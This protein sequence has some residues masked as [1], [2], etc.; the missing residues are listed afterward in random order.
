MQVQFCN[1]HNLPFLAQSGGNGW[2]AFP[3]TKDLVIINLSN[4]NSVTVAADKK[5]A[6]IGGGAQVHETIAA[7]DAAGVVV[8]TGNCNGAGTLGVLLG[9]GYGNMMGRVG[10]GVDSILSLRLVTATGEIRTLSASQDAALFWAVKGAGPNFG[11]VTCATVR[12][13]AMT[14]DERTAWCGALIYSEDKLEQVVNAIQDLQLSAE[15]V[16]FMYFGSSGPPTHDPV[17]II[18][19]WL[20]QGTPESGRLAF[21]TLYDIGPVVEN[22][23]VLPYTQWNTGANPFCAHGERKPACGAGMNR[24]DASAWR[25]VWETYVAF[26]KRPTAHA[27]VVLMEAYPVNE[28]RCAGEGDAAFAHRR[29][30][31]QAAVLPWY[32]DAALDDEA[33]KC[34]KSVREL[35][36][37]SSGLDGNAT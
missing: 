16:V 27:S 36:R 20:F 3:K 30:R 24:L 12:A 14:Q 11:I 7:A 5:T 28:V 22:T 32:T 17:I 37:E 1:A 18:T 13:Y 19:P 15:M 35:W 6:L 25:K 10:F 21:K 26:Q 29:V 23:A 33:L 4:L 34:G 2:A 31:F 8:Q 9:G